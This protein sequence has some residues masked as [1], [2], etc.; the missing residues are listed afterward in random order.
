MTG[1]RVI[2][3]VL[4]A[5][6][7]GG[8]SVY[9]ARQRGIDR[10]HAENAMMKRQL[11]QARLERQ[12]AVEMAATREAELEKVRQDSLAL[13]KLREQMKSNAAPS[14]PTGFYIGTDQPVYVT[15]GTS[16]AVFR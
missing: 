1:T 4:C 12:A 8:F 5:A 13:A 7:V 6:I 9:I 11:D 3:M 2:A 15:Y 10:V 14:P 16:N